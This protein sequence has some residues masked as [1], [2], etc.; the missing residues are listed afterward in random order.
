MGFGITINLN[1]DSYYEGMMCF[2]EPHG[3]GR[4][5]DKDGMIY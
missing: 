2:G 3:Y 1:N 4:L 5:I